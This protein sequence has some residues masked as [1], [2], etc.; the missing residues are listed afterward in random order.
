[1]K[2]L[3]VLVAAL[4]TLLLAVAPSGGA[5]REDGLLGTKVNVFT[6]DGL[7]VSASGWSYVHH[8]VLDT[9]WFTTDDAADRQAFLNDELF[10]FRLSMDGTS[11][12]LHR[13]L[14]AWEGEPKAMGKG[15]YVQWKPGD[16]TPGSYTLVGVWYGDYDGDGV[17][18]VLETKTQ[19]L[20]V[21]S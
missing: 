4:A 20:Q 16:L 12:T 1:M 2:R 10:G 15:F 8:G 18:N 17:A 21:T 14:R 13:T 3:L 11:V 7:V 5:F 6:G 9:T 19:T